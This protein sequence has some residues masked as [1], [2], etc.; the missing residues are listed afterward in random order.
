MMDSKVKNTEDDMAEMG[1]KF[2]KM[3][4]ELEKMKK[5]EGKEEK[6]YF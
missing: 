1:E 6:K 5:N 3:T 2:Q 4:N